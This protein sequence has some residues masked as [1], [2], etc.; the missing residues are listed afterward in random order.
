LLFVLARYQVPAR[1]LSS[2]PNHSRQLAGLLVHRK[3]AGK[4]EH[5]INA[6]FIFP[7]SSL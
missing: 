2:T 4:V 3:T 7:T 5:Q 6:P 1:A